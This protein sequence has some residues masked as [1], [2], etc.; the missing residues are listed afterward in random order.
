[1]QTAS[2]PAP[3]RIL[4]QKDVLPLTGLSKS[5]LWNLIERGEFPAP[6]RLAEGGRARGWLEHEII[7]WQH[8]RIAARNDNNAASSS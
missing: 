4:R 2:P 6:I 8:G 7:T 5:H 3:Q 1:M